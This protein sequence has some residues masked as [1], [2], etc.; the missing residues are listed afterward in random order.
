MRQHIFFLLIGVM[1]CA[2]GKADPIGG[3]TPSPA[4]VFFQSG[5]TV[6]FVTPTFSPLAS[7]ILG[8]SA[9]QAVGGV[10]FN[11][12][13]TYNPDPW[14][15]WSLEMFSTNSAV[16]TNVRVGVSFGSQGGPY[17]TLTSSMTGTLRD[18]NGDGGGALNV[19]H[20]PTIGLT[21][22]FG[23][24]LGSSC[25]ILGT[26]P[27]NTVHSCGSYGPVTDGVSSGINPALGFVFDSALVGGDFITYSGSITLG[28]ADAGAVPEP[29]T[30]AMMLLAAGGVVA[31]RLRRRGGGSRE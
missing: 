23:L 5:A 14:M 18:V 30:N 26:Y 19:T 1:A 13:G 4:V 20:Y 29:S 17:D 27:A 8:F 2:V 7:G 21:S 25:S 12:T 10:S 6:S 11:L 22:Q 9:S 15:V 3:G 28:N 31:W 16:L 24:G